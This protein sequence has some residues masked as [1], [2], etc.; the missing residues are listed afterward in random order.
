ML[1][2]LLDNIQAQSVE[3]YVN[4]LEF[5]S[6]NHTFKFFITDY[7]LKTNNLFHFPSYK[8]SFLF[9]EKEVFSTNLF[10]KQ[11]IDLFV[12]DTIS[13]AAF[14]GSKQVIP[15][16]EGSAQALVEE[17]S[18]L[19]TRGKIDRVSFQLVKEGS[20]RSQ[21]FSKYIFDNQAGAISIINSI[22][23]TLLIY[24][25]SGKNKD[26][27]WKA[28]LDLLKAY[29]RSSPPM[30]KKYTVNALNLIKSFEDSYDVDYL[31][32]LL[33]SHLR[34]YELNFT[35]NYTLL[36][37]AKFSPHKVFDFILPDMES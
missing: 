7:D 19:A 22:L 4:L 9:I 12:D 1:N 13:I 17:V 18:S 27:S 11:K 16:I 20:M 25:V 21:Y 28:R 37:T 14:L 3:D 23:N 35:E 5:I 26:M 15:L 36:R 31:Y 6:K 30:Y 32:L 10:R 33:V 8:T 34:V 24:E 2:K 29:L